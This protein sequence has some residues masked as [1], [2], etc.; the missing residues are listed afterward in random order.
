M[1]EVVLQLDFVE[2]VTPHWE[3]GKVRTLKAVGN[4]F[5]RLQGG[6]EHLE[7]GRTAN[8]LQ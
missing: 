7:T 5:A 2:V 6:K 1:E 4:S 3:E 8:K